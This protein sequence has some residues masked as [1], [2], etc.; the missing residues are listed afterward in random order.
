MNKIERNTKRS[1]K[2]PVIAVI[3][4]AVAAVVGFYFYKQSQEKIRFPVGNSDVFWM[5]IIP[6]DD[7]SQNTF[8]KMMTEV[9]AYRNSGQFSRDNMTT[10][11][12][13]IYEILSK[14]EGDILEE[15]SLEIC[16]SSV[17]GDLIPYGGD[18]EI[19]FRDAEYYYEFY[20]TH[21]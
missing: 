3:I 17:T 14:Y 20:R 7:T 21:N 13:K 8:K 10:R 2:I 16:G 12:E 9:N 1:K 15:G 11:G 18:F 6:A 5:T 4:F 19:G